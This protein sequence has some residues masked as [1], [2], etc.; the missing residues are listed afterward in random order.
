MKRKLFLSIFFLF[1]FCFL[2][3]QNKKTEDGLRVGNWV[4]K[5]IWQGKKHKEFGVYKVV[6]IKNYDT[7]R[8]LGERDFEIRHKNSMTLLFFFGRFEDKISVK[9]GIWQV[10][11]PL[12]K[13][14]E[15]DLWEN[16]ILLGWKTYNRKGILTNYSYEDFLGDTTF[17]LHYSGQQLFSKSFY[18]PENKNEETHIYYPN[19]NLSISNAEPNFYSNFGKKDTIQLKISC[20]QAL[21]INEISS[22]SENIKFAYPFNVLPLNL[23]TKDTLTL[24][25]IITS[26]SS[27]FRNSETITI[28][29]SEGN[30]PD[31][32]IYCSLRVFHVD[33]GNIETLRELSLSKSRDKYLYISQM[34]SITD[35]IISKGKKEIRNI[36]IMEDTKI[37][38][39]K[40]KVGEYSL[41]VY[42]CENGG[43]L[44]LI[45]LK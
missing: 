31:Y 38:L 25:L 29:T 28:K 42:S 24:D 3:G 5:W 16:G 1:F 40:L 43:G 32:K 17:Y 4:N 12:G 26:N 8:G 14:K 2:F 18:P 9:D 20:K 36:R 27:T 45:I 23:A 33:G 22:S 30:V 19:N 15:T 13:I 37:N 35:A 44:K 41:G 6:S 11:Y 10:V 34:G 39:R 21:S 7:I